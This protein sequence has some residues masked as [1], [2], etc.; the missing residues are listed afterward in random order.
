MK[1]FMS[2]ALIAVLA[3]MC[4]TACGKSIEVTEN[5]VIVEKKGKI[6]EATV[7]KL[8][9]DYYDEEELEKYID[10]QV[11]K[12]V[13]EHGSKSM[14]VDDFSVEDGVARLNIKYAGYGDYSLFHGAEMFVGTVEQAIEAGYK[15]DADFVKVWNGRLG[16]SAD[17]SEITGNTQYYVVI[18]DDLVNVKIDGTILYLSEGN[19]TL[20]AE[21]TA[22]ITYSEESGERELAYIIYK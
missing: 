2:L 7:E 22:A 6:I 13:N 20:K 17:A 9:K 18:L 3:V 1:K 11:K 19:T 5:T 16:D 8:D 15:F 21:D 4:L 14:V 10:K 12:Y